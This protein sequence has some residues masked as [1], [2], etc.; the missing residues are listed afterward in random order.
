[1]SSPLRSSAA[2]PRRSVR[3]RARWVPAPGPFA[4]DAPPARQRAARVFAR[5]GR[6]VLAPLA[7]LTAAAAGLVFLLLL[8]ICGIAT[9]AQGAALAS[10]GAVRRALAPARRGMMSQD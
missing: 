10:W 4:R 5:A 9:L 2:D 6:I 8:P 1:V 3:P 7:A